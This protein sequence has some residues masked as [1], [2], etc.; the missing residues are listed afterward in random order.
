LISPTAPE[1]RSTWEAALGAELTVGVAR[2]G[3]L[4]LG[5]W[6]E[7]RTS[8]GPVAGGEL[9]VEGLP[10]HPWDSRIGGAGSLVLRAGGNEHVVTGALGFGYVGSRGDPWPSWARHVVGARVVVSMNRSLDD[11]R[12]WSALLGLEVEPIG[13]VHAV[14]DLVK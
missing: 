7:I 11:P 2:E 1:V 9:V 12:D 13:A 14:I 4:R 10:P 5:A 6:T 8:S 3:D